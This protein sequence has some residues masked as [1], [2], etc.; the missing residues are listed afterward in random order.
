MRQLLLAFYHFSDFC[1]AGYGF[2][3]VFAGSALLFHSEEISIPQDGLKE[4][5]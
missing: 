4:D 2:S 5:K 1:S 3:V